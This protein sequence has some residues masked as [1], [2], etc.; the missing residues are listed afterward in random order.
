MILPMILRQQLSAA[1]GQDLHYPSDFDALAMDIAERTGQ[2][3]SVNTLKRLCGLI[4]PEVQP[5]L[6][7]QQLD[8]WAGTYPST[9]RM[10]AS[11]AAGAASRMR[12]ARRS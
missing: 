1:F 4:G 2:N 5:R 12:A 11:E 8:R 10:S 9:F 7:V 3:L 6:G